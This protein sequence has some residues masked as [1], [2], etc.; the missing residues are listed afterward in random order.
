VIGTY[1]VLILIVA[2]LLPH[3]SDILYL[4]GP[5]ALGGLLLLFLLRYVSTTYSL[6]DTHLSA[7]RIFGGRRVRLSEVRKIEYSSMRDLGP[8]GG[9]FG[10]WGWRGRMWSPQLGK[11]DAIY[12][13]AARGILVTVGEI[14]LYITPLDLP[15]FARELS[16][17]VRSY[18]G[19]L[20]TD[21]GD[22]LGSSEESEK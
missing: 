20:L 9:M 13:D 17:R 21:V 7:W 1:V 5:W 8:T 12:T 3:S 4:Y 14:P 6:D 11:F 15:E 18:T 2:V 22:P 16:R 19:R 10:S